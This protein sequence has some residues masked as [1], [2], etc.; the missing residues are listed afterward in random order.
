V[1]PTINE[2]EGAPLVNEQEGLEK[3]EA[4]PANEH[5]EEHKQEN[6]DPQPIRRSQRERRSAI[7]ND[8]VVYMSEDI[9]GTKNGMI[10]SHLK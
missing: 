7:S 6:D 10:L 9:N 2:N 8:Y 4:P 3:N 1:E 5:K